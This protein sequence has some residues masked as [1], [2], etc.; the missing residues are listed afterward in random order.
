MNLIT[1]TQWHCDTCGTSLGKRHGDEPLN[2]SRC[3]V[4]FGER[5]IKVWEVLACRGCGAAGQP[6]WWGPCARCGREKR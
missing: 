6:T 3:H 2:C 4:P 5:E 1:V